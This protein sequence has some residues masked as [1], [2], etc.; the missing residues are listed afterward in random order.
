MKHDL[1][2][3]REDNSAERTELLNIRAGNVAV[4][5]AWDIINR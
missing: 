1:E 3:Y 2:V 4:Q 5:E